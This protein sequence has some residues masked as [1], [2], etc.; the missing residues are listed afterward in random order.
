MGEPMVS[1]C[2]DSAGPS[3]VKVSKG[4]CETPLGSSF[5]FCRAIKG[6][7]ITGNGT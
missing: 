2:G 7:K 6:N 1:S 4:M 5:T 3:G